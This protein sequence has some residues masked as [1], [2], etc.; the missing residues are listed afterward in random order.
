MPVTVSRWKRASE[1]EWG[2][3]GDSDSRTVAWWARLDAPVASENSDEGDRAVLDYAETHAPQTWDGL[4]RGPF[5]I[6]QKTPVDWLVTANYSLGDSQSQ[7]EDPPP[8]ATAAWDFEVSLDTQ[9]RYTAFNQ[10]KFGAAAPNQEG[11]INVVNDN[12]QMRVEGVD[13]F[14]VRMIYRLQVSIPNATMTAA[15]INTVA[16]LAGKINDATFK[17]V[18][19]GE[20]MFLGWRGKVSTSGDS[21]MSFEFQ[22][23][24]TPNLPLVVGV[25]PNAIPIPT[26]TEIYGWDIVEAV[27]KTAVDATVNDMKAGPKGVYVNRVF[28][29]GDFTQLGI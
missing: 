2:I 17:G 25:G 28:E 12:G 29:F 11:F 27:W 10:Q 18:P 22:R 3:S 4:P 24:R 16:G 8:G 9:R 6:E 21:D 13:V 23:R 1:V 15:Y 26:G 14:A 5:S 7:R 19:K 20:L